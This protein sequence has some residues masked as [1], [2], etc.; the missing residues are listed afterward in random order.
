MRPP[1]TIGLEAP[2]PGSGVFQVTFSLSLQRTGRPTA[3]VVPMPVG[4]RKLGQ[5]VGW[6]LGVA[7]APTVAAVVVGR[8]VAV[9]PG[10][11]AAESPEAASSINPARA[12][13]RH[14]TADGAGTSDSL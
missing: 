7:G 8:V 6:A 1:K 12:T 5:S 13:Q 9:S 11:A 3:E 4:P 14:T 10:G 2:G